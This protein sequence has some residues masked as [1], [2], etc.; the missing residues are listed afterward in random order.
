MAGTPEVSIHGTVYPVKASIEK[1]ESFSGHADYREM[2]GF[3]S[4]QEKSAIEKIFIVHGEY[5]TQKKYVS[6]LEA[7]GFR[8]LEIPAK[9]Q[10]YKI[11]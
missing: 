3:L 8:N 11:L 10:E 1:I 5:E 4:C 9:G 2:I 7:A 6:S